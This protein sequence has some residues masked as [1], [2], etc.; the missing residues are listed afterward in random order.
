MALTI[1]GKEI[2]PAASP[3]A[4]HVNRMSAPNR[5]YMM[6]PIGP[7]R[8]SSINR[9]YPVITGGR[10]SG[11]DTKVSSIAFPGIDDLTRSQPTTKATGNPKSVPRVAACSDSRKA[12]NSSGNGK[13]LLYITMLHL[14]GPSIVQGK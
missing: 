1:S 7:L 6:L 12:C 5:L 4:A 8:A 9:K 2:T 3:M 14:G 11:K 13:M 10:T